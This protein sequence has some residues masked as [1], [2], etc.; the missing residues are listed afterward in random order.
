[1]RYLYSSAARCLVNDVNSNDAGNNTS[2]TSWSI[3]LPKWTRLL[4]SEDFE[5]EGREAGRQPSMQ[6]GRRAERGVERGD[7]EADERPDCHL[8]YDT[9]ASGDYCYVGDFQCVKTGPRKKCSSC[10]IICHIACIPRLDAKCK[11]TFRQ[12]VS[13][14]YRDKNDDQWIQTKFKF[15]VS[16]GC[17]GL[18]EETSRPLFNAKTPSKIY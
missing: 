18:H 3:S 13:S 10:K 2:A 7:G 1:M 14:T 8:W 17:I 16:E 4:T 12:A 15:R 9:S 11:P 5:T 6:A